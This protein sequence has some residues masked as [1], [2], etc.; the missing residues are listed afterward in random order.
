MK[1]NKVLIDLSM[2]LYLVTAFFYFL[3]GNGYYWLIA[4][5]IPISLYIINSVISMDKENYGWAIFIGFLWISA[6]VSIYT[7][8]S[9]KYLLVIVLSFLGK[10]IFESVYGWHLK[11]SKIVRFFVTVHVFAIILS[12]FSPEFI[13]S[14]VDQLY[15]GDALD[16]YTQLFENNAYAGITGQTG[17]AAF[18]ASVFIAFCVSDILNTKISLWTIVK[19]LMGSFALLLTVKRSF[20]ISNVIAIIFVFY[21]QNKGNRKFLKNLLI[22]TI[23]AAL[24]YCFVSNTAFIEKL[25]SKNT[26]LMES[27]DITNGRVYLWA[28]TYKLWLEK[29]LFGHGINVLP[30]CYGISTHNSFLQILAEA[31]IFG[32]IGMVVALIISFVKSCSIYKDIL[33]DT[34]LSDKEKSV[35]LTAIYVQIV[36]VI[37]CLC[38]NPMY[39]ISFLLIDLLFVSCIKSFLRRKE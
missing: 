13:K 12:Y 38:G 15:T 16:T 11:F 8:E 37:Y 33:K 5:V 28:E 27:G 24:A 9:Y 25:L 22:F 4:S 35:F 32:F 6:M 14:I 17:Y 3:L 26:A 31:G 23:M 29:P 7:T 19:F 20:I 18:F 39:G 2:F 36:F 30:G 34:L 21:I 10:L 1:K